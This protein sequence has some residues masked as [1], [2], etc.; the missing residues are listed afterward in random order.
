VTQLGVFE[1]QSQIQVAVADSVSTRSI[2]WHLPIDDAAR[3]VG[4]EISAAAEY[5]ETVVNLGDSWVFESRA[6]QA[7]RP[8]SLTGRIIYDGHHD[9]RG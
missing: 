5:A 3:T 8:C 7:S 1:R 6:P 2:R 9:Q 4:P